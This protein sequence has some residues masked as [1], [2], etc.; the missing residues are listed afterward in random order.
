MV[1]VAVCS[2]SASKFAYYKNV[3]EHILLLTVLAAKQ[4]HIVVYCHMYLTV[5]F[6]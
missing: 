6:N 1:A 5:A 3:L 4:V 2:C